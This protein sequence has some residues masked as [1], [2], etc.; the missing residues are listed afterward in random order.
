MKSI[1]IFA[2]LLLTL[3][4]LLLLAAL[5]PAEERVVEVF[6]SSG[7]TWAHGP[8][9][10]LF[11]REELYTGTAA[12]AMRRGLP[13]PTSTYQFMTYGAGS[14]LTAWAA[15]GVYTL[16]GESYLTFKILPLLVTL[17]G[18]LF[19]FAAIRRACGDRIAVAFAALYSLAPST[20]VRTI[21][22]AKGDHSEAMAWIGFVLWA[23]LR[24]SAPGSG[25]RRWAALAGFAAGLGVYVTYSTV[26]V[27]AGVIG[28]AFLLTRIRPRDVWG[29]GAAGLGLGLVPW[30]IVLLTSR[31]S[32][33]Q[34]Y[35]RTLGT[36]ESAMGERLA[37]LINTG[38]FAHYDLAGG[39]PI[40]QAAGL[41]FLVA[42]ISGWV[43]WVRG[44]ARTRV[45]GSVES[46][47]E[48]VGGGPG[49]PR[50]I[51]TTLALA[52]TA[53][54]LAAFVVA[55]PD[56]ASRYLMPVYPLLLLAVASL[57][58]SR[59][60]V[61]PIPGLIAL[62][63]LVALGTALTQGAWTATRLPLSGTDWQLL[64]EIVGQKL[65]PKEIGT[66]PDDVRRHFWVG[67]GRRVPARIERS[68][69]TEGVAL[70]PEGERDAV[71]EGVGMELVARGG[72]FSAGK[73][74][75]SLPA[76]ARTSLVRG[77][78]RYGEIVFASLAANRPDVD[79][80]GAEASMTGAPMA[81][82]TESRARSVATLAVHGVK[83]SD[84]AWRGISPELALRAIGFATFAGAGDNAIRRY[85]IR[86]EDLG[87]VRDDDPDLWTGL[88]I[89]YGVE[90]SQTVLSTEERRER[91]ERISES[92]PGVARA[93]FVEAA[94][95][96]SGETMAATSRGFTP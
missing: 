63:G 72:A 40:R 82:L 35:G 21:L 49:T 91:I 44:I 92:V 20:F 7:I 4:V 46:A 38:F 11:D 25:Q 26:P 61:R 48:P 6:D 23:A 70:A 87:D 64:G 2:A 19:W 96:R 28:F 85:P 73:E 94:T 95:S 12:E 90:L 62:L 79:L 41:L 16:F 83:I 8:E 54:H 80:S 27:L 76:P 93:Q 86:G 24:A 14:L 81:E 34:V 71:W 65:G 47:D 59:P 30:M 33:L 51:W 9:R 50:R 3:R 75:Q 31:G 36:A 5:E 77:M 17:L 22:I 58:A 52:G 56:D 68:L 32:A 78:A 89:A 10:P 18:G 42:V 69:W 37:S 1:L 74:I 29:S 39:A 57:V 53:A 43:G 67:F 13:I 84:L 55:A 15:R 88:G 66:L 60:S 45:A